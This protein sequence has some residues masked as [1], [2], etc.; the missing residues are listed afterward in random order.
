MLLYV[1]FSLDFVLEQ[2]RITQP[3]AQ[4]RL[5]RSRTPLR[6]ETRE[7]LFGW[8][9]AEEAGQGQTL[10]RLAVYAARVTDNAV[11]EGWV[12]PHLPPGVLA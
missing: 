8:I 7:A 10:T 1:D 4:S 11:P 12:R 6:A 5:T 3:F 2:A 9:E